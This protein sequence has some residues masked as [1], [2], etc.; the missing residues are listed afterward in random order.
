M[1]GSTLKLWNFIEEERVKEEKMKKNSWK[2][3]VSMIRETYLLEDYEA[4]LH[5]KSYN[6]KKKDMDI[7]TCTEEFQKL[8]LRS[9]Y[10]VPKSIKVAR[11]LNGSRMSTKEELHLLSPNIVDNCYKLALKGEEKIKR[12]ENNNK[13]R[14]RQSFK[15]RGYE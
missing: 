6:I 7:C 4:Q 14:G 8:I 12:Q 11:Y 5:Q 15:G 9:K 3:I 13:T 10:T 1:K 2:K